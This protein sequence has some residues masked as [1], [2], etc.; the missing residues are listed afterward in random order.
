MP[1]PQSLAG[2]NPFLDLEK[3]D[4]GILPGV[5]PTDPQKAMDA[6]SIIHAAYEELGASPADIDPAVATALA[7]RSIA[8]AKVTVGAG[9]TASVQIGSKAQSG[10]ALSTEPSLADFASL[11]SVVSQQQVVFEGTTYSFPVGI[12]AVGGGFTSSSVDSLPSFA[13]IGGQQWVGWFVADT[14]GSW[15]PTLLVSGDLSSDALQ[16][17][18]HIVISRPNGNTS[19]SIYIAVRLESAIGNYWYETTV[20]L[21]TITIQ[22]LSTS[23]GG[24]ISGSFTGLTLAVDDGVDPIDNFTISFSAPIKAIV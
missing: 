7:S 12:G 22:N 14:N 4:I 16:D 15:T 20:I 11:A 8:G 24:I 5:L 23:M 1:S 3:M 10:I 13:Y 18:M 2:R 19:G 21:P 17:M 9:W 6:I